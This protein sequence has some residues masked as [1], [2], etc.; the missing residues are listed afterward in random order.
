MSYGIIPI[1]FRHISDCSN[2]TQIQSDFAHDD[3]S[4]SGLDRRHCRH[5]IYR[6]HCLLELEPDCLYQ[7]RHKYIIGHE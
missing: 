6:M 4:S 2:S 5:G 3:Y 7:A 1:L